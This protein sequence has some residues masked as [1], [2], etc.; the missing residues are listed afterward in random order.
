M[1]DTIAMSGY[2]EPTPS[3]AEALD[4]DF[5]IDAGLLGELLGLPASPRSGIDAGW[6]DYERLRTR[7][8]R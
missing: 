7:R 5:L 1:R 2:P 3:N 6:R 8:R 4:G